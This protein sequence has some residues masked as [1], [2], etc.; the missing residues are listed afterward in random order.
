MVDLIAFPRAAFPK[1][2]S[3]HT[4]SFKEPMFVSISKALKSPAVKSSVEHC[5]IQ[6]FLILFGHRAPFIS[7]FK[8]NFYWSIAT[9]QCCVSFCCAA[10]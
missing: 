4:S 5:L 9:L 10:K 1:V 3:Q 7:F 8:I 2:G 6:S